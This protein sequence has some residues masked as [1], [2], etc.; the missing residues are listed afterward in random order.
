MMDLKSTPLIQ[1]GSPCYFKDEG[2]LNWDRSFFC[3]VL[4]L[5]LNG[6]LLTPVL[7]VTGPAIHSDKSWIETSYKCV[8]IFKH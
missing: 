3:I 8:N 7:S 5:M 4:T 6:N 1:V 2:L